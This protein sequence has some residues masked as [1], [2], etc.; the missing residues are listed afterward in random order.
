MLFGHQ[1][2]DTQAAQP[3]QVVPDSQ[4]INPLAVDP[5][6][7]ASLP[8]VTEPQAPNLDAQSVLN[9]PPGQDTTDAT[10]PIPLDDIPT[11]LP[12]TAEPQ[13]FDIASVAT[14]APVDSTSAEPPTPFA[15]VDEPTGDTPTPPAPTPGTDALL[16]LKQQALAQ[17]SPLIG[18]LDQTPEEKF[19]TT[20][21]MIQ[22]TDNPS[23]IQEAYDAAQAVTDEKVRAQALLDVINEINYFTQQ[24]SGE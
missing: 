12:P 8:T 9:Q 11:P 21:M 1:N 17:L 23:L 3:Q 15:T 10:A 16:T 19:R 14:P 24:K 4:G 2:D 7:G 6:T 13:P 18:Q 5:D 20:M 22:S